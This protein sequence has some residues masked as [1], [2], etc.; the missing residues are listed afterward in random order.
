MNYHFK[1]NNIYYGDILVAED[2]RDATKR[3]NELEEMFA[4]ELIKIREF[5]QPVWKIHVALRKHARLVDRNSDEFKLIK[6]IASEL[7]VDPDMLITRE[8]VE[9]M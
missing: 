4:E 6:C 7:G 2:M 9:D 8:D 3:L 5:H 1:N